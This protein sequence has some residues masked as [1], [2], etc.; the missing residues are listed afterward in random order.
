MQQ[1]LKSSTTE[2]RLKLLRDCDEQMGSNWTEKIYQSIAQTIDQR[3]QVYMR[4][5][6]DVRVESVLFGRNRSIIVSSNHGK[7]IMSNEVCN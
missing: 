5:D 6:V 3:S 1:L 2:N 4:T 7:L